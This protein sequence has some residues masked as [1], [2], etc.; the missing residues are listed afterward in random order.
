MNKLL[1]AVLSSLVPA[2]FASAGAGSL[3][4]LF[5]LGRTI[6][7]PDGDGLGSSQ[8]DN[9]AGQRTGCQRPGKLLR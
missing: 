2:H 6:L 3:S 8:R 5:S 7:D 1:L 4:R 9:E